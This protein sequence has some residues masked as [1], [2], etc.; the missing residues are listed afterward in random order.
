M[1]MAQNKISRRSFFARSQCI[2]N[3]YAPDGTPLADGYT[4]VQKGDVR[5]GI[6]GM[7]TPNI[8]R[9]DTRHL[10]G[11]T[12]TSPVFRTLQIEQVVVPFEELVEVSGE[13]IVEIDKYLG[14]TEE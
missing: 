6:I 3:V 9:W 8:T 12:V 4:I 1:V 11:W 5:I 2:G 14:I 13:G 7:V 10:E